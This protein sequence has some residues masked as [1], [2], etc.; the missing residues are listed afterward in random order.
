MD[1]L[2]KN[3]VQPSLILN[4]PDKSPLSSICRLCLTNGYQAYDAQSLN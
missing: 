1:G 3:K 2:I 4:F